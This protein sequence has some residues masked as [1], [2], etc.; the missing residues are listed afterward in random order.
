MMKH[1]ELCKD[2]IWEFLK[3]NNELTKTMNIETET[4]QPY[5]GATFL[6][7]TKHENNLKHEYG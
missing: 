6:L 3:Y 4:L 7:D 2:K 5:K 1:Q